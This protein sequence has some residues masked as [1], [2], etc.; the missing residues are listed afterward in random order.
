[1]GLV[2]RRVA[3]GMARTAA[4]E[5]AKTIAANSPVGVRNAKRAL[6]AGW[7][8]GLAAGLEIEDAC[9]RATAVSGDRHEG[10]SAFNEK[11]VPVWPG[12]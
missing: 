11:R 8:L 10:V 2:D 3:P 9:W 1:M 6:R 5:L 7:G 12:K 4:L